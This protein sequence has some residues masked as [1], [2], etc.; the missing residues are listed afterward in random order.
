MEENKCSLKTILLNLD[1]LIATVCLVILIALTFAGVIWRYFLSAP[2]TWLEE[3]QLACMVW[4]VF[5]AAGPAFR[6]GSHVA[7]EMI[8]DMLPESLQKVV[9]AFISICVVGVIVYLFWR[10]L[11]FVELFMESGRA[12][13]LLEMPLWIVYGIALP[14]YIDMI[15]SYFYGL[16]KGVK[17][18][19][20]EAASSGE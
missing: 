10:T 5:L 1:L 6:A 18:E 14:S 11:S 13:S 12:T 9:T 20:K 16:H 7:I 4:I 19:V 2:F 8:A 15:L 3:V 17:S